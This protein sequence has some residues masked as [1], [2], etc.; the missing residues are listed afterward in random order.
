DV[1]GDADRELRGKLVRATGGNP[2]FLLETLACLATG[3]EL[4][5]LPLAQGIA[6]IVQDRLAPLPAATRELA[7]AAAVV[8]RDVAPARWTAASDR[9]A[10]AV[11]R[12]GQPLGR[13]GPGAAPGRARLDLGHTREASE[14]F[15]ATSALARKAGDPRMVAEAALAFGSRYVLGDVLEDLIAMIDDAMIGLPASERELHAR[16]LSRKAAALTPAPDPDPVLEMAREAMR[17]VAGS[18]DDHARREV[19]V[20][21][22]P[23]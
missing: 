3:H 22:C 20:A 19:A 2:L 9:G 6:A 4:A 18:R 12:G 8:G 11:R 13:A 14:A 16:L 17:L 21:A 1:R 23:A 7:R 15:H 10:D 5:Q